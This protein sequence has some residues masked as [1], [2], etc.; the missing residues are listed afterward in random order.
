MI[1]TLPRWVQE[2][3]LKATHPTPEMRF[4]TAADFAEAI[5]GKH[6]AY[7][8]DSSRIRADQYAAQASKALEKRKW[9]KAFALCLSALEECPDCV[10]ALMAA[11]RLEL[12]L[13][14][15]DRA[16]ESFERAL[17]IG[18]ANFGREDLHLT[19]PLDELGNL[20]GKKGDY[21]GSAGA[22]SRSLAIK[23]KVLKPDDVE[24]A[25]AN[26]VLAE[27]YRK[28][29]DYAKA[30]TYYQEAIRLYSQRGDANKQE[31]VEALRRYL[32]VLTTQNRKDEAASI[33]TRLMT[34]SV[35]P[36]VVE[37]GVVNGWAVRLVQPAYP[38]VAKGAH[39]G[40]QVQV[41]VLIDETGKVI[42][43]V[44]MSGHP[45]LH[46]AAIEA[47]KASKFTPTIKSGIAVKVR[48]TIIYNFVLQ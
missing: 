1:D 15:L 26:F 14:H 22:F 2:V 34:L 47:A 23:A 5:R 6:V 28:G 20:H 30:D 48:G 16:K 39:A 12:L 29:R 35:E 31:L 32:I 11:G 7:I 4:Q 46:G 24:I 27:A 45:L 42:S 18:E 19:R 36:G 21:D 13:H 9:K 10:P 3:L 41:Q 17:A 38:T 37:G 40:G 8:F 43:A 33:Q 44:A 25:R